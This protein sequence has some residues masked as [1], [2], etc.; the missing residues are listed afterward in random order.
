ML[1]YYFIY[2]NGIK[3]IA[4]DEND[5]IRFLCIITSSL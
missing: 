1:D 2:L 5:E 4:K 3:Q